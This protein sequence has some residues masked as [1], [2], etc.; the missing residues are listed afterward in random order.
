MCIVFP[1][2]IYGGTKSILI[3]T[4]TIMGGKNSFLG[5]AYVVVGGACIVLGVVF[6]I[7]HLIKPRF[8]FGALFIASSTNRRVTGN[9]ATIPTSLGTTAMRTRQLLLLV[10]KLALVLKAHDVKNVKIQVFL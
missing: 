6:T 5:I 7:A 2:T 8:V 9:W 4:R 3:S 1:V 10:A